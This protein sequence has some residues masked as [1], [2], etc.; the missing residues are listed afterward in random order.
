VGTYNCLKYILSTRFLHNIICYLVFLLFLIQQ[1]SESVCSV[2]IPTPAIYLVQHVI[3]DCTI[4]KNLKF[5][6]NLISNNIWCFVGRVQTYIHALLTVLL[7]RGFEKYLARPRR[8]KTTANKLGIYSTYSPW[9]SIRFL[10]RCSNLYKPL[11]KKIGSLS[12]LLGL[13]GSN[14]LSVGRK[15]ATFQ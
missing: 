13:R 12:V 5:Y 10:A 8:K 1:A 9:S 6:L 2:Y 4:L 11:K 3:L 14:D 15:M 7:R